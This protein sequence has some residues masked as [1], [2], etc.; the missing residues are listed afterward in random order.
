MK[1]NF[2]DA[3]IDIK[4]LTAEETL[5]LEMSTGEDVEDKYNDWYDT[6]LEAGK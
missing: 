5:L 1:K 4:L 3:E 6:D 2:L